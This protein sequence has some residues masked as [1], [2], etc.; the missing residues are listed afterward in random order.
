VLAA[1]PSGRNE[2]EIDLVLGYSP[3]FGH[4]T[5]P[6]E[7]LD[8]IPRRAGSPESSIMG[9]LPVRLDHRCRPSLRLPIFLPPPGHIRADAGLRPP[10]HI[11]VGV[12]PRCQS[13]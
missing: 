13:R 8:R 6:Q 12:P 2:A 3:T 4:G 1:R 11:T 9:R 7:A 5:V 10:H